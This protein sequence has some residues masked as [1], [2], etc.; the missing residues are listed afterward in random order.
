GFAQIA[1]FDDLDEQGE[2][3]EIHGGF[4]KCKLTV[5]Q[6]VCQLSIRSERIKIGRQAPRGPPPTETPFM[7]TTTPSVV[8]TALSGNVLCITIDNPPVNAISSAVR[9]GLKEAIEAADA[10]PDAKA[11]LIVGEGANFVAGAD[12]REFGQAP[13]PPSLP[14]VCN[15]IEDA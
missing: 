5:C 12:I 15:R 14:E 11:I 4:V 1:G 2:G 6:S 9:L 3:I 7:T 13:Q 8:R 10:N